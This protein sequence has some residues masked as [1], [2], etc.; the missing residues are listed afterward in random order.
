MNKV[1]KEMGLVLA[2]FIPFIGILYISKIL[3]LKHEEQFASNGNIVGAAFWQFGVIMSSGAWLV[4][5]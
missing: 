3:G 2:M 5:L 1:V 4:S